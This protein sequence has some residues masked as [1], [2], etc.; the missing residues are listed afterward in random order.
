MSKNKV[1]II[2]TLEEQGYPVDV[3]AIDA[4]F[5]L[6]I[7][8]VSSAE[9]DPAVMIEFSKNVGK[10][11]RDRRFECE[12]MDIVI[13]PMV[14]NA[15]IPAAEDKMTWSKRNRAYKIRRKLDFDE[16]QEGSDEARKKLLVE[17]ILESI[18]A[19]PEKN[20]K[21]A[22]KEQLCEIIWQAIDC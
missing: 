8:P 17:S 18:N 2:K 1:S 21:Q 3:E 7:S 14:L 22:N 19:I 15:E 20:L 12:L 10:L 4:P 6:T 16:W 9:V 11:I 13:F 5:N